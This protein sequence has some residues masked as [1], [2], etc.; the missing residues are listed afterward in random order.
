MKKSENTGSKFQSVLFFLILI[1]LIQIITVKFD[2]PK[3]IFPSPSDVISVL[4]NDK[5]VLGEHAL[6][7]FGEALAGFIAAVISGIILGGLLGYFRLLRNILYPLIL[8]SQMVPL[9]AVAPVI[10]IW[11]GFGIM[12]KILIVLTVCIFPCILSFLDGLDNIDNELISLMKTMKAN[13]IQIFFKLKLPASL[14]SL[15]SGLK[16]SAVYSIM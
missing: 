10:L 5:S 2:I 12:P 16:I 4:W 14:Q 13:E 8:I 1:L 6:I 15:L 3:Y 11:F 7:T 9:I